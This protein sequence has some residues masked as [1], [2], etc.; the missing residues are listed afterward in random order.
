MNTERSCCRCG[1][2]LVDAASME[3]GIG[4]VCR[5][6]DNHVL[7]CQFPRD[8]DAARSALAFSIDRA[9]IPSEALAT[10]ETVLSDIS[11]EKHSLDYRPEIKRIEWLLSWPTIKENYRARFCAIV[12][13]LGYVALA[14]IWRNES[15]VPGAASVRFSEGRFYVKGPKNGAAI[16]MLRAIDGRQFHR[17]TKEWSVLASALAAFERA[18]R[19]CYPQ[20]DGSWEAMRVLAEDAKPSVVEEK[21]AAPV[22]NL[23]VL[24]T[25]VVVRT[26]YNADFVREL[27]ELPYKMRKWDGDRR[28]WLVEL[29]LLPT[30]RTLITKHYGAGSVAA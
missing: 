1:K 29:A 6:K 19:T 7:A 4:P 30:V 21:P 24:K 10:F 12:E 8:M 13:A 26:P 16:G 20:N 18:V 5:K 17:E 22:V 14:M 3:V 15:G 23:E 28:A 2:Q 27:K 25:I 9:T 11:D